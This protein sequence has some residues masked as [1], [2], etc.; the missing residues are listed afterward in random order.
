MQSLLAGWPLAY[1]P[2]PGRRRALQGPCTWRSR[3]TWAPVRGINH[4]KPSNAGEER[5]ARQENQ[6]KT[7]ATF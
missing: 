1:H 4:R 2:H 7:V 5:P 3:D 6:G